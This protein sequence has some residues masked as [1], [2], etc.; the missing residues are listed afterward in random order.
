MQCS[1]RSSSLATVPNSM[2]NLITCFQLSPDVQQSITT[3]CILFGKCELLDY[4]VTAQCHKNAN[5]R[6]FAALNFIA[7]NLM[8]QT[9]TSALNS[10]EEKM[11]CYRTGLDQLYPRAFSLR[12][13]RVFFVFAIFKGLIGEKMLALR[14]RTSA[15]SSASS[16]MLFSSLRSDH[17]KITII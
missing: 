9:L 3:P 5:F 15:T 14:L 16:L 13:N 7:L 4:Y 8:C 6:I 17:L 11:R 10:Y 12:P 1:V 2:K